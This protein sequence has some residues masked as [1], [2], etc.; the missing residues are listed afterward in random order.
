M[1][2]KTL[3][4]IVSRDMDAKYISNLK[5]LNDFLKNDTDV[6]DYC[7]ISSVDDFYIYEMFS[8]IKY[9]IINTKHQLSKIC[10]FI[11]QYKH[12]LNYDWYI[13]FRPE[14]QLLEPIQF[15]ML[16][17]T[18]INARAR[19]YKG[20]KQI[21]N[22]MT[23]ND[24]INDCFYHLYESE[25][26]LDDQ[27]YIFH[28]NVIKLGGFE[29]FEKENMLSLYFV[30]GEFCGNEHEWLHSN[31]W[32]SKNISLNVIGINLCLQKYGQYSLNMNI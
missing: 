21:K 11:T 26:V 29:S 19:V 1:Y 17:N 12:E 18:S 16:S 9:K 5:L 2:M 23:I 25:L 28:N 31:Y 3:V 22:A 14:L 27:M 15:N 20:P 7:V 30:N 24:S 10:D 6:I 13:K 32:K 4:I 8:I